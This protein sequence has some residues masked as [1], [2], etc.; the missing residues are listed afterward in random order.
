MVSIMTWVMFLFLQCLRLAILASWG[1]VLY[2]AFS[3]IRHGEPL[4]AMLMFGLFGVAAPTGWKILRALTRLIR[5]M[6]GFEFDENGKIID[7]K[8]ETPM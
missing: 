5:E 1:V 6:Q 3:G 4:K 2:Q 7:K 8:P